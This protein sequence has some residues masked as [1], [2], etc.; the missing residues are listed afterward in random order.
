M[1]HQFC[2][3]L[4]FIYT[5][6]FTT[7]INLTIAIPLQAE[8]DGN[9]PWSYTSMEAYFKVHSRLSVALKRSKLKLGSPIF[10]RIF[11]QTNELELWLLAKNNSFKLFK[12]YIICYQSGNLGPKIAEGDQQS[13]EG[14][15]QVDNSQ[16]NPWSKYHL[17]FN[18]GYP[19]EYDRN[20][21]RTGSALMVHGGC[22]S[23]GC[24]AMTDYFMDEIYSLAD[25]ALVNGQQ[26]FQVHIFPF[27]L[28]PENIADHQNSPWLSF[29]QNLKEGY[30]I[31]EV[32][33]FP[34]TVEVLQGRYVFSARSDKSNV[35]INKS[36]VPDNK[37]NLISAK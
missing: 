5:I 1:S 23:I 25:A 14:F 24:F 4:Q 29:W 18:L 22:S 33:N 15:Y 20:L 7:I 30:D 11:K 36:D 19:N 27:R 8:T 16:M 12:T 31:F 34:P 21:N 13:P 10:I 3:I 28:S 35:Q 17:S 2:K 26:E 37:N 32:H 6:C 9:N